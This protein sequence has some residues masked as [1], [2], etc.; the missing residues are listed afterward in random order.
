MSDDAV[1][2]QAG[3]GR[4]ED[5]RVGHRTSDGYADSGVIGQALGGA[6]R[7]YP[8]PPASVAALL[9]AGVVLRRGGR[10]AAA[11]SRTGGS[12]PV[13]VG[14]VGRGRRARAAP[15]R[16]S[17]TGPRARR[18]AGDRRRVRGRTR[19]AR[20]SAAEAARAWL[21][22]VDLRARGSSSRRGLGASRGRASI[23]RRAGAGR[24]ARVDGRGA[25]AGGCDAVHP[26]CRDRPCGRVAHVP[27]PSRAA[28]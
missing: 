9:V 17:R 13:A 16:G 20:R 26:A 1:S 22:D 2:G 23:R 15:P 7:L 14:R 3:R 21:R 19:V 4:I 25:C 24:T 8:V 10:C 27:R 18:V 28:S 5:E 6:A 11:R 12:E